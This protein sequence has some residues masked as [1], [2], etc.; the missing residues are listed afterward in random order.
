MSDERLQE[1]IKR[2]RVFFDGSNKDSYTIVAR[3]FKDD[4]QDRDV[5]GDVEDLICLLDAKPVSDRSCVKCGHAERFSLNSGYC[6]V[7]HDDPSASV[8]CGCKCIYEATGAEKDAV[9]AAAT[10][11]SE[12]LTANRFPEDNIEKIA[13]IITRHLTTAGATDLISREEAVEILKQRESGWR[14]EAE[15]RKTEEPNGAA[16]MCETASALM[17]AAA[18]IAALPSVQQ[19]ASTGTEKLQHWQFKAGTE[20]TMCGLPVRGRFTTLFVEDSN[21][22]ACQSAFAGYKLGHANGISLVQQP[23]PPVGPTISDADNPYRLEMQIGTGWERFRPVAERIIARIAD[24]DC[25]TCKHWSADAVYAIAVEL[26]LYAA[27][28][29]SL[30]STPVSAN[31]LPFFRPVRIEGWHKDLDGGGWYIKDAQN[32]IILEVC[33][34][35]TELQTERPTEGGNQTARVVV[36]LINDA[37]SAGGA[38]EGEQQSNRL[39]SKGDIAEIERLQQQ[40][41]RFPVTQDA[42][43][44]VVEIDRL[45]AHIRHAELQGYIDALD[46][47]TSPVPAESQLTHS[48]DC[49]IPGCLI[50][51]FN[52]AP[53]SEVAGGHGVLSENE[54]KFIANV[55]AIFKKYGSFEAF[56]QAV[57]DGRER[58]ARATPSPADVEKQAREIIKKISDAALELAFVR[59]SLEPDTIDRDDYETSKEY[60]AALE[61]KI[62]SIK[63][64]VF[65]CLTGEDAGCLDPEELDASNCELIWLREWITTALQSVVAPGETGERAD[66][67][68]E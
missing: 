25:L 13:A 24:N 34:D 58:T 36:A 30:N 56:H 32:K 50:C 67:D 60:V 33:F 45:L 63:D 54:R 47:T 26:A 44:Y 11:L 16:A 8:N 40:R 20:E 7:G 5:T 31:D 17:R 55:E 49:K 3:H 12:A 18:A 39:L 65:A 35:D 1:T 42:W 21:C 19:P 38:G 46:T 29:E 59:H 37:V 4:K 14:A 27:A 28:L 6:R 9:I 15:R 52:A 23:A 53:E 64:D 48:E 62:E 57:R 68:G 61:E 41:R 43:L 10:E 2:L 66:R 22:P 51:E